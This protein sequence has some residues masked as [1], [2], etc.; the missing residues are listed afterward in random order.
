L[1]LDFST[2]L[3]SSTFVQWNNETKEVNANFRIHYIP[4]IGSD[5]YIVYNH[6]LD[7]EDSFSSLHNT[8]MLK[9]DY[10]YRF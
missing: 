3:S 7:E 5:M 4:K 2:R 8:A 9:V 10:T 6:L 1:S